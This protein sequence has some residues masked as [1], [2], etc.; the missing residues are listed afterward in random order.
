MINVYNIRKKNTGGCV[1]I[2]E[3]LKGFIEEFPSESKIENLCFKKKLFE[4][5]FT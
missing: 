4:I 1:G 2:N 5:E 3:E